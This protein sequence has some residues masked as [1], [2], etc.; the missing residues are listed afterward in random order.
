MQVKTFPNGIY[1]A[2]TYL[3]YDSNSKE[4]VLIDC[5]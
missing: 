1:G 2:T 3:V 5:H 4:A